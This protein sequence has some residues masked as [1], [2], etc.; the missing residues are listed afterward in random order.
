MIPCLL[1]VLAITPATAAT[2]AAD[3]DSDRDGLS[4]V[5]EVHKYGTDP[6]KRDSDGDG[7][8]DGDWRERREFAYT[9]RTVV[10]VMRPVTIEFLNDDYQDVR[11]L[12]EAEHYVELEVIHYPFS[13]IWKAPADKKKPKGL[14]H[15]LTAGPSSNASKAL[16]ME[17]RAAMGEDGLEVE[18]FA[19]K[20]GAVQAARWLL[21]RAEHHSGFTSFVTAFDEEGQPFVPEVFLGNAKRNA[22]KSGLSLEEQWQREVLAAGMFRTKS[23]G[24]CTS[25]AIYLSGCLRALGVP[26]RTVLCIPVIDASDEDEWRLMDLGIS[27]HGVRAKV[28]GALDGGRQAWTSHTFNEVYVEGRWRRLNYTKLDQ[29]IL[30]ETYLGLMTHVG[31]FHDWADAKFWETVG[32]RQKS[33]MGPDVFGHRNPYSTIS[34]R[35]EFGVHSGLE[36]PEVPVETFEVAALHWMDAEELPDDIRKGNRERGR[37]GLIAEVMTPSQGAWNRFLKLADKEIRLEAEGVPRIETQF[38]AGCWWYKHDRAFIYV[39]LDDEMQE[40]L[41][42]GRSMRASARNGSDKAK[43]ALDLT[44]K[45]R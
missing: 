11:V 34:L 6:K 32:R 31:T 43:W 13:T 7:I 23:R 42:N 25:S 28:H 24:S 2:L 4:D 22:E 20:D 41:K 15:W 12:D 14:S 33:D 38:H 9:V 8:E 37:F 21:A 16:G 18:D 1:A 5:H 45:G 26:T 35:D 30:D 40:A 17:I 29:G 3:V 27:H 36:N 10:H 19:T 39:P 44:V